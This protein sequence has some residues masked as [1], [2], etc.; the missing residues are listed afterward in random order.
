[1]SLRLRLSL[2]F[3]AVVALVVAVLALVLYLTL[4]RTL[5]KEMDRRLQVRADEVALALWPGPDTPT[6]D[7]FRADTVDLSELEQLGAT[8]V[9]V[10][11]LDRSGALLATFP[12][13][14]NT[15]VPVEPRSLAGAL[16]NHPT[17]GN[18]VLRNGQPSRALSVP[19]AA[20]G[21]LVG[22]LQVI[23][24]R[25]VLNEALDGLRTLLLLLGGVAIMLAGLSGW[26][27]SY[28]G[29]R[30]LSLMS[31]Q[32]AEI[33][34]KADFSQR[35]EVPK[36]RDE[37]AQLAA[38][39][40][41][42]LDTVDDTLR[43]H[44]NF[45]ADTSHELRNPLLAIRTN[46]DLLNRVRGADAR[47]ECLREASQ[48]T[49][50]MSRLVADLLL[51]AQV[52]KRLLID[53]HEVDL[54]AVAH[55]AVREATQR[56]TGQKLIVE[57]PAAAAVWGDEG[58]LNQI[59]DNLLDN[60]IKH[61]PATG[62]ITVRVE[63][64]PDGALMSVEDTGQGIAPEHLRRIFERT[65]QAADPG[66]GREGYGLGLAIVKHLAEAHDG[67]VEARSELGRG[68]CISVWLPA[69]REEPRPVSPGRG[70][71]A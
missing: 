20:K 58:R 63:A 40:D 2:T 38:T 27:V 6:A 19:I 11:I 49:E 46:L 56:A 18:G 44:R 50:R 32:A 10:H 14:G 70:S 26:L 5:A 12:R 37:V 3:A 43:A 64:Q 15:A 39:V 8:N 17:F 24:P 47:E 51:L 28:R 53:R 71:S 25:G 35:I 41:R 13:S 29:L 4:A 57:A 67:H 9:R 16:R 65:Y 33:A 23:Q 60:A 36:R 66:V 62:T 59:L 48:Q 22:V 61:T 21:Q 69:Q 7:D 52:E 34:A 54:T 1:M 55:R 68:T 42:L 30:P 45:L 31:Q